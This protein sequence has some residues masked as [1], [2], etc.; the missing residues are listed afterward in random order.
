MNKSKYNN[1]FKVSPEK[2]KFYNTKTKEL[3]EHDF[4]EKCKYDVHD[5][6]TYDMNG[7]FIEY[8]EQTLYNTCFL[9]LLSDLHV[10]EVKD[11]FNYHYDYTPNKETYL[12]YLEFGI[13]NDERIYLGIK[14]LCKK[15]INEKRK[16]LNEPQQS[17]KE[18]KSI[19]SI[20]PTLKQ[21][22]LYHVYLDTKINKDN[23]NKYLEGTSHKT[24]AKLKQEF[25]NYSKTQNR[26]GSGTERENGFKL[27]LFKKVILM[28]KEIS[29][30]DA[31]LRAE[32]ELK[33]F[34]NNIA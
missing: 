33:Q 3:T 2:R 15:L 18:T 17:I 30:K 23:A 22:A 6:A 27:K 16:E 11:F 5:G 12:D 34:E 25:D 9:I 1:M 10:L 4:H 32:R 8:G 24:G 28:L 29:N 21:L 19:E 14:E 31:V 13:L 20:E 7:N 26:T